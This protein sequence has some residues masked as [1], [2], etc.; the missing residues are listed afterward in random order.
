MKQ[1]ETTMTEFESKVYEACRKIPEG[2][3]TTYGDIAKYLGD[4]TLSRAVGNAL[5]KNPF[6]FSRENIERYKKEELVPCHRVL[7]AKGETACHFGL[8]GKAVQSELLSKEGVE[9]RDF[10]VDLD[11]YLFRF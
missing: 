1:K 8:G 10:T 7:N 2:K 6:A 4:K 5:H 9:V 3:V 11:K